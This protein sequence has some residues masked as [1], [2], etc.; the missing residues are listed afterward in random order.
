MVDLE[1]VQAEELELAEV[2][3]PRSDCNLHYQIVQVLTD[4]TRQ[5]ELEMLPCEL[6]EMFE[7]LTIFSPN[8]ASGFLYSISPPATPS[9]ASHVQ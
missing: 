8:L 3:F 7:D 1:E 6:E 9:K 4:L 5:N 2:H